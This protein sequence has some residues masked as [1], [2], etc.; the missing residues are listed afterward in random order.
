MD[1]FTAVHLKHIGVPFKISQLKHPWFGIQS[2]TV[3]HSHKTKRNYLRKCPIR[4]LELCPLYVTHYLGGRLAR[5][6]CTAQ[7]LE[8][9][10]QVAFY[11]EKGESWGVLSRYIQHHQCVGLDRVL[12][13]GER[14]IMHL[15]VHKMS[16]N[17]MRVSMD[18]VGQGK[19]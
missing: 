12:L 2:L 18:C 4:W 14:K 11:R 8:T 9:H 6:L 15:C 16:I 5:V 13:A 17:F 19:A 10:S 1:G 3:S 7:D